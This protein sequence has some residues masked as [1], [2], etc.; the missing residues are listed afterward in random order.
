MSTRDAATEPSSLI[1]GYCLYAQTERKSHNT[2]DIVINSVAYFQ[3]FLR[4]E[5]LATEVTQIGVLQEIRLQN[6]D[7]KVGFVD[8]IAMLPL[9]ARL[10]QELAITQS[11]ERSPPLSRPNP[12][13]LRVPCQ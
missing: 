13:A 6:G 3:D 2:I 1:Q 8:G 9:A 7:Y 11:Q 5:G 4:S 10:N 12:T